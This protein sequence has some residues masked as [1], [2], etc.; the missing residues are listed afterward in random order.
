MHIRFVDKNG[1]QKIHV[2][3]SAF[4]CGTRFKN[5]HVLACDIIQSTNAGVP[6]AFS[7]CDAG[8][9]HFGIQ[10]ASYNVLKMRQT[11]Y[12]KQNKMKLEEAQLT[13]PPFLSSFV[14]SDGKRKTVADAMAC[15]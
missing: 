7:F 4:V 15:L 14:L 8:I 11:I 9:P 13:V 5:A 1:F 10:I 12:Y 2:V 6:L 3:F